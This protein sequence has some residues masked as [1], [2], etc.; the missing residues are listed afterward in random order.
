MPSAADV[1]AALATRAAAL[2]ERLLAKVEANLSGLVLAERSG[3]LK[4][5]VA[6][7]LDAGPD[8]VTAAIVST[9]VPYAAI[10]ERGGTTPARDLVPVKAHALAFAGGFAARVHHPGSVIPA[11]A[12]FGTAF[13]ALRDDI[14]AGLKEAVRAALGA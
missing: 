6:A 8:G 2:Q 5:S 7:E 4:A 3:A 13:D 14:A 11:R 10:Q 9:G 12:P 1:A